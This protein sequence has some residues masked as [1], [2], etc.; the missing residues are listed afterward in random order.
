MTLRILLTLFIVIFIVLVWIPLLDTFITEHRN[1]VYMELGFLAVLL[2]VLMSLSIVGDNATES[3]PALLSGLFSP[4]LISI[5][6]FLIGCVGLASSPD[7]LNNIVIWIVRMAVQGFLLLSTL[8]LLACSWLIAK[9][10]LFFFISHPARRHVPHDDRP[11]D[12]SAL[13][14]TLGASSLDAPPSV[15]VSEIQTGKANRLADRLEAQKKRYQAETRIA[16]EAIERERARSA[17]DD[18]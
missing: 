16:R 17:R 6:L 18:E 14:D 10:I 12:G 3:E 11:I 2:H 4:F 8:Y 15:V 1:G 13:A 5:P 9:G 7:P